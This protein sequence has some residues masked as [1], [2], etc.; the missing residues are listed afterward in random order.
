MINRKINPK[1]TYSKKF[2]LVP[3]HKAYFE[4]RNARISSAKIYALNALNYIDRKMFII[5]KFII[6]NYL[7]LQLLACGCHQQSSYNQSCNVDNGQCFCKPGVVGRTCSECA[8]SFK[9]RLFF[10]GTVFINTLEIATH[11]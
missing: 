4:V 5:I 2:R 7:F 10:Y 3:K 9:T 11:Y 1:K 8:V 6:E